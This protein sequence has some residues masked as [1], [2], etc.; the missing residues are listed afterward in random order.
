VNSIVIVCAPCGKKNRVP[1]DKQHLQPKCGHCGALLT[2]RHQVVPVELDDHTFH[3]FVKQ[4]SLPVMVDFFSPTCD[5]CQMM[6]PIVH[7]IASKYANK[8]IVAKLNTNQSQQIASF[9]N[10]RGVPSFF[11]FK[12]GNLV[13]QLAGAVPENV[14]EQKL[15]SLV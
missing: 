7:A 13:D 3:N 11:F 6:M 9:F 4:A 10:I 14:L 5:P 1:A 12:N 2:V 15:S 8:A